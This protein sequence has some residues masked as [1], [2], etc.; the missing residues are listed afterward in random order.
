MI[1]LG[2]EVVTQHGKL[3]DNLFIDGNGTVVAAEL[4]KGKSPR[5]VVAQVLDYAAYASKLSWEDV[6]LLCLKRQGMELSQTFTHTFERPLHRASK[7]DHRLLIMA[8]NFDPTVIAQAAYLIGVCTLQL[9]LIE[10]QWFRL[11]ER[12]ILHVAPVLGEI[13]KQSDKKP[14]ASEANEIVDDRSGEY[15]FQLA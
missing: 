3:V 10:F 2:T 11:G 6:D 12:S 7:P 13:P 5:E 15:G 4:K 8:E 9:V 1:S 14:L